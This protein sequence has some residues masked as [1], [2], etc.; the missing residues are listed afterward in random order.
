MHELTVSDPEHL[1]DVVGRS[2][3]QFET[4]A[5]WAMA[6]KLFELSRWST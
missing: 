5:K 2:Q 4:E 6:V 1:P 3:E